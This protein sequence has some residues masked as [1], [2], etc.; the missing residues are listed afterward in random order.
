[1]VFYLI[2]NLF[3]HGFYLSELVSYIRKILFFLNLQVMKIRMDYIWYFFIYLWLRSTCPFA[4]VLF[5]PQVVF[6]HRILGFNGRFIL[7]FFAFRHFIGESLLKEMFWLIGIFIFLNTIS[8][9]MLL[10][11]E[12]AIFI[13]GFFDGIPYFLHDIHE[14]FAQSRIILDQHKAF[15]IFLNNHIQSTF[16]L[17]FLYWIS[18]D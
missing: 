13:F 4:L 15:L 7:N 18:Y 2:F 10:D 11:D 6:F 3:H 12:W 14:S 5:I 1:M 9:L 17:I 16:S 8:S